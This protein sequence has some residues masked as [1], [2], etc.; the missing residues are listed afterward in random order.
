MAGY[1]KFGDRNFVGTLKASSDDV[2]N[3]IFVEMDYVN[4]QGDVPSDDATG[5]L[6]FVQNEI[7]WLDSHGKDDRTFTVDTGASLKLSQPKNGK[8]YITDEIGS[9][10]ASVTQGIEM[11]V[12]A[13]GKLYLI[14][15]LT[16]ANFTTFHTTFIVK[17]KTTL[18]GEEAVIVVAIKIIGIKE[19]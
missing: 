18:W 8:M 6:G 3:G 12:G 13:D 15:D 11:G 5:V 19:E 7:D 10:Y 16:A 9:T 4:A 2:P 17:E 1:L 14:A